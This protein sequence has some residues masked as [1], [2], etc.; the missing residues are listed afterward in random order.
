[1][2]EW[3]DLNLRQRRFID[4]YIG[5][6]CAAEAARLAGYSKK[7]AGQS[8][9]IMK[10]RLAAEIEDRMREEKGGEGKAGQDAVRDGAGAVGNLEAAG[11]IA[12]IGR[13]WAE[14]MRDSEAGVRE[15]L[16]ASELL[17]RA[18]ER[19]SAPGEEDG[20]GV[21]WFKEAGED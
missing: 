17:F 21:N 14:L 13:F 8:G 16:K 7:T 1:M 5:T 11:S 4:G 6:G 9:Y 20:C 10:K 12:D 2:K 19:A 15:R 3:K 18:L